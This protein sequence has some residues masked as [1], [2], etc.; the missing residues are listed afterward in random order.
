MIRIKKIKTL[1]I[2]PAIFVA[3]FAAGIQA[4]EKPDS[5]VEVAG[6]TSVDVTA[7]K[8][9][10]DDGALFIDVRKDSDWEAGRIPG[11][12]HLN[13]K[14]ALTEE[15]LAEEVDK[16]EKVVFYCNGVKCLRSSKATK[17]ALDWGYEN[18]YYFRLGFPAWKESGNAVE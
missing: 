3:L 10:F 18:V 15:S 14:S 5:P 6:A 12:V 1:V 16:T 11:A 9:L 8:K 7:A 17:M 4:E 2:F 13:I